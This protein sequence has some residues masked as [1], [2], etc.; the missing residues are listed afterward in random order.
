MSKS[1]AKKRQDVLEIRYNQGY[2][3]LDR[4]GDA[5]VIL[6]NALPSVSAGSLWMPEDMSP[7][8]ARMK[9]PDLD[10]VLVF[11][12]GR[13]CLDQNPAG[14]PCE[15]QDIAKYVFD[16]VASKFGIQKVNRFGRRQMFII[17][18]DSIDDATNLS[19]KK[20]PLND[21]PVK[22]VDDMKHQSCDATC[23][24][25]NDDRSRGVRFSIRPTYKVDAPMMIDERLRKPPHLLERGQR[26]ALVEQLQRAKRRQKD[27][28]AG[29]E[30]DVDCWWI[31]PEDMDI[32]KF[33][34]KSG[35]TIEKLMKSFLGGQR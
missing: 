2:R 21:W 22:E 3:Y 29:L 26:E 32:V 33:C 24:L 1:E 10:L 15:M 4:C 16:T 5:M 25:E 20:L 17:A 11:D 27:P 35:E 13:L 8:G 31:D 34:E 23:V 14:T 28:A 7:Q 9:C 30:V 19:I 6:E 12:A 18:T